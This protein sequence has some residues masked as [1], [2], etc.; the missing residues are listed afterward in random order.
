M[1]FFIYIAS[2]FLI[3]ITHHMI[4]FQIND[5]IKAEP[6][7]PNIKDEEG[8]LAKIAEKHILHRLWN[9][10][11]ANASCITVQKLKILKLSKYAA[12]DFSNHSNPRLHQMKM[13]IF[14]TKRQKVFAGQIADI[15]RLRLS[16]S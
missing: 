12:K 4:F 2:S 9:S 7:R 6:F 3:T 11:D 14:S 16:N 10:H 1:A 15:V 8:I 13:A 5:F